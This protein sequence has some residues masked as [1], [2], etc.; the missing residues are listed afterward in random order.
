MSVV[1]PAHARTSAS[2]LVGVEHGP[3]RT[4][5]STTITLPGRESSA[6]RQISALLGLVGVDEDE[7]ERLAPSAASRGSVSSARAD[8]HLDDVGQPG[9]GEVGARDLGMPA[10]SSSSVTSRP[11]AGSARASQIVL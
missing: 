10:A 4:T 2:S 7:V 3:P 6:P 9:A 1:R 8:A 5:L 11:P